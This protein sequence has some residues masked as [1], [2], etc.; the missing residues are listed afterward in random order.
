DILIAEIGHYES[1]QYTTEIF[2][3]ILHDQFP[4]VPA[5]ITKTNTNPI[6]YL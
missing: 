4:E 3:D 2:R 1:E 6:T 5:Q